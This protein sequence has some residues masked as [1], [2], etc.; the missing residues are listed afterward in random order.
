MSDVDLYIKYELDQQE[1][2]NEDDEDHQRISS[3]LNLKSVYRTSAF[4][5]G[6]TPSVK[7]KLGCI[8]YDFSF[9]QHVFRPAP[10]KH[11]ASRI[12]A[13]ELQEIAKELTK[14]NDAVI[15][16]PV[17]LQTYIAL[18]ELRKP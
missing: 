18:S 13:H 6:G 10:E 15:A 5:D 2:F 4:T 8:E 11:V 14:L 3:P 7:D 9:G 12:S 16:A 17:F 1:H